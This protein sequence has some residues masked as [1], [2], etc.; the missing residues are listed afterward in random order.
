MGANIELQHDIVRDD[1]ALGT[2]G[3]A[4]DGEHHLVCG[5]HLAGRDRLELHE[6]I[7]ACTNGSIA[8]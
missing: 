6:I 8:A 5:C 4:A 3:D 7:A 1:V 2:G